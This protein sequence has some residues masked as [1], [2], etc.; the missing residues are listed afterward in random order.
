M[1]DSNPME[2]C[3]K[4]L[5]EREIV[6][7]EDA[8]TSESLTAVQF[9]PFSAR[10]RYLLHNTLQNHPAFQTVSVGV[11]PNRHP[12]VFKSTVPVK[13]VDVPKDKT[14]ENHVEE[15]RFR[16]G[17]QGE[18]ALT[19]PSHDFSIFVNRVEKLDPEFSDM[20]PFVTISSDIKYIV[21]RRTLRAYYRKY[22]VN[23]YE[24][25]DPD[26]KS[27]HIIIADSTDTATELIKLYK[28]ELNLLSLHEASGNVCNVLHVMAKCDKLK[29]AKPRT[30]VDRSAAANIMARHLGI[31]KKPKTNAVD[32]SR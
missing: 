29:P 24:V 23:C 25:R 8:T 31:A 6:N 13:I 7:I 28:E 27:N 3:F 20:Y 21:I 30:T 2:E 12:I 22:L 15:F 32:S 18:I 16:T 9:P 10:L 5:M 17:L 4:D 1:C 11:E 14:F 19:V 26:D